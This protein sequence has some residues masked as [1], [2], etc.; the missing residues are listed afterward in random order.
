MA[1]EQITTDMDMDI[2]V[3]KKK[4][5]ESM[6][7]KSSTEVQ[8]PFKNK[9]EMVEYKKKVES[10]V[11]PGYGEMGFKERPGMSE[12]LEKK[13]NILKPK[14]PA[15]KLESLKKGMNFEEKSF[16]KLPSFDDK[17]KSD[18]LKEYNDKSVLESKKTY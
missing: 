2:Q 11:K 18:K 6:K 3:P 13:S 12:M 16:K 1:L 10:I 17:M 5:L 15:S 9:A 8:N 14:G 7:K 4:K